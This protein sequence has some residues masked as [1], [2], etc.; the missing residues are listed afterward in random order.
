MFRIQMLYEKE[1]DLEGLMDKRIGLYFLPFAVLRWRMKHVGLEFKL[2]WLPT[3]PVGALRISLYES[4]IQRRHNAQRY[5]DLA[6]MAARFQTLDALSAIGKAIGVQAGADM[7]SFNTEHFQ[8]LL[9]LLISL[10]Q[11]ELN[12]LA[13]P[14]MNSQVKKF[15]DDLEVY[16]EM[17]GSPLRIMPD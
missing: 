5:R 1:A 17:L 2:P 10:S 4:L 8:N 7:P 11:R 12:P 16:K 6:D 3:F 15:E 13:R 14:P 9:Q